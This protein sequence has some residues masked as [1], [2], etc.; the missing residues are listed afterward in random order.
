MLLSEDNK[1]VEA[2]LL[3][4]LCMKGR[5]MH[6]FDYLKEVLNEKVGRVEV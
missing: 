5:H 2:K 1:Q 4:L 6:K 3:E